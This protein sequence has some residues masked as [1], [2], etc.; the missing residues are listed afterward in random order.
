MVYAN[1]SSGL[2]FTQVIAATLR[3][4]AVRL[5]IP[6][7]LP[8]IGRLAYWCGQLPVKQPLIVLQVQF[9]PD[10]PV[11]ITSWQL[12]VLITQQ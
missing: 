3:E 10:L 5:Q 7:P 12:V 6:S 2:V 4:V 11:G 9:L 1:G 8:N